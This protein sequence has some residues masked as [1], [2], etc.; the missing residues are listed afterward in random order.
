[1][2]DILNHRWDL[3]TQEAAEVQ[4]QLAERVLI[5]SPQRMPQL[6]AGLD[7]AF[8]ADGE[9]CLAAAVLWDVQA[10][11]VIEQ[12]TACA[13]VGFPY[14]PGFL[15][16]R[17]GPALLAALRALKTQPD[18]LMCDGQGLAHP[19]RLGIAC[20]LGVLLN[21]PAIGVGKTRLVGKHEP[22]DAVRGS[23]QRLL[24]KD[25]VVG[26]VLRTRTNV[27][28]VYPGPGH[29]MDTESAVALTLQCG[30]GYRVPEPTRLADQLAAVYKKSFGEPIAT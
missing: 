22:V 20:H 5:Q 16:F 30:G 26:A 7:S 25:E 13:P 2:T 28:C 21:L 9:M 23:W 8:S 10:S 29:L 1:M 18:G 15:S 24:D 14:I 6:V 11:Q 19:R 3:S 27:K 12:A 4:R 17:E